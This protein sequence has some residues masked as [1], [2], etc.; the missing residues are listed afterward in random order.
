MFSKNFPV[1]LDKAISFKE[2]TLEEL[3]SYGEAAYWVCDSEDGNWQYYFVQFS[4]V[5]E[6]NV[7]I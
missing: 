6:L 4:A 3:L 2:I 5:K 1:K 7:K